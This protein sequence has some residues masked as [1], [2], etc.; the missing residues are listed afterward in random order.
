[1]RIE[2]GIIRQLIAQGYK[3]LGIRIDSMDMFYRPYPMGIE[4]VLI[5]RAISGNEISPEEYKRIINKIKE[6][7]SEKGFSNIHLL[8]IIFS[9]VPERARQLYHNQDDHFIV[10]LWNRRLIIYENQSPYYSNLISMVEDIV[11]NEEYTTGLNQKG[12]IQDRNSH[13]QKTNIISFINTILIVVNIIIYILVHHTAIFGETIYAMQKGALYWYFVKVDRE[14]YRLLTSM[15]LHSDFEHLLNNMLV[16]FFVGDNLERAAG[17]IKYL[18]IYFGSGII[19]GISSIS[20]NMIKEREVLSVGAS[21]AIFGI[22]GAMVYILLINKG[23]LEDISSRQII[24]FTVFSL[25]GGIANVNI[26]N[27]AHIGGFI[28]GIILAVI[29]YRRQRKAKAGEV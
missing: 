29:L 28:G 16:L 11:H 8:G 5:L 12:Y 18:V 6:Y 26:D 21:G 3:Q 10:D 22:V 19:A 1:M 17:K 20:Y 24:L 27:A 4:I 14:H 13:N 15:F 7:F 2:E 9:A 23:H 25:Y